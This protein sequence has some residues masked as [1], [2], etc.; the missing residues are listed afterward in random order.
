M[1]VLIIAGEQLNEKN[2]IKSIF[3]INQALALKQ[4]HI[5]VGLI[6]VNLNGSFYKDLIKSMKFCDI[7]RFCRTTCTQQSIAE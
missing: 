4:L 1:H 6:A 5:K 3:E 7:F 2:Q